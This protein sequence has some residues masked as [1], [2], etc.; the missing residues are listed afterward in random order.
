MHE[1][2]AHFSGHT[3]LATTKAS[4]RHSHALALFDDL[5]EL[6]PA[7]RRC[8]LANIRSVDTRL[9]EELNALLQADEEPWPRLEIS[10]LDLLA[11]SR[12]SLADDA[13]H[14]DTSELRLLQNA[15]RALGYGAIP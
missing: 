6:D 12:T 5:V 1:V 11:I 10:P 14:P 8:V 2:T 4:L 7:E 9:F 15:L 13:V 3:D